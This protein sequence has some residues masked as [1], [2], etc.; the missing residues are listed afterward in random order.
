MNTNDKSI[1]YITANFSE[2]EKEEIIRWSKSIKDK[3]LHLTLVD[4]KIEGGNVTGDLHLTLFYGLDENKINQRE[5]KDFLGTIDLGILDI[6]E[7]DVFSLPDQEYKVLYLPVKDTRG[8]INR[9][10]ERLKELSYFTEYQKFEFKPH[11]TIAFVKSEFDMHDINYTGPK[12]LH[13][14][15][16]THHI[17][18]ST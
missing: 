13:V 11:I 5:L 6:G 15:K 3:D 8:S 7:M 9:C 12:V 10:R 18:N 14:E 2:K 4:G 17:K 1:G 16:I